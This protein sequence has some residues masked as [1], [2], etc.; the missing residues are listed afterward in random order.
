[1]GNVF[2]A[3]SGP[4]LHARTAQCTRPPQVALL[5]HFINL[6]GQK[7]PLRTNLELLRILSILNGANLTEAQP[8][9]SRDRFRSTEKIPSG[10]HMYKGAVHIVVSAAFVD[11]ALTDPRSDE[12]HSYVR[13]YTAVPDEWFFSTLNHNQDALPAPGSPRAASN[14]TRIQTDRPRIILILNNTR[15]TP[16]YPFLNRMKGWRWGIY[17]CMCALFA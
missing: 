17:P 4:E 5:H 13:H 8:T 16:P 10:V 1:M 2:S 15:A 7:F 6:T 11:F 14:G 12:L 3:R 9:V